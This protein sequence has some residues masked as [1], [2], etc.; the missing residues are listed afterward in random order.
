MWKMS[1]LSLISGHQKANSLKDI[2]APVMDLLLDKGCIQGDR[3]RI[4]WNISYETPALVDTCYQG[5]CA[6]IL[7]ILAETPVI[8]GL[9]ELKTEK[10]FKL[11]TYPL[12]DSLGSG[13]KTSSNLKISQTCT[14]RSAMNV[15]S[16]WV[17][18]LGNL[19]T[20]V[21]L[22][23]KLRSWLIWALPTTKT[24]LENIVREVPVT[25]Y[26]QLKLWLIDHSSIM[27]EAEIKGWIFAQKLTDI[28]KLRS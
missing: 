1:C 24:L 16:K 9:P 6:T 10:S 22:I 27:P 21:I 11:W 23:E 19:T 14:Q 3:K 20:C 13:P 12:L 17:E 28:L 5:W 7:I 15:S 25:F 2:T 26:L 4:L 18:V 8:H